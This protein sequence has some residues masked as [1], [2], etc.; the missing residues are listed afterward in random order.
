MGNERRKAEFKT[1]VLNE[2]IYKFIKPQCCFPQQSIGQEIT[3]ERQRETEVS[4][5]C[6]LSEVIYS[7]AIKMTNEEKI[8]IATLFL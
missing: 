2:V 7:V 3:E 1:L 5:I 6:F 4:D 8:F